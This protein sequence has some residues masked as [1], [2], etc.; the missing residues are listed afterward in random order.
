[1][2]VTDSDLVAVELVFAEHED[3]GTPEIVVGS[4]D[5]QHVVVGEFVILG[6][7]VA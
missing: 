4:V 3:A 7:D 6:L 1:M 2:P 5:W